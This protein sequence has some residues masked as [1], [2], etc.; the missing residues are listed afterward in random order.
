MVIVS[1]DTGFDAVVHFWTDR[2]LNVRRV[3]RSNASNFQTLEVVEPVS[4]DE[5]VTSS[6][7]VEVAEKIG[8][9]D[10]TEIYTIINCIGG[11]DPSYIH[12]AFVHFY[13]NKN[14]ENIYKSLK[15]EKFVALPVNWTKKTK[16]KKFIGLI[17]KY[18][19]TSDISVPDSL[20]G[21]IINNIVD[22]KKSMCDKL[23]KAYGES[24]PQLN[25]M[26]KP[27]YKTLTR[28]KMK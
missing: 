15:K 23:N 24:G 19:N 2:G 10:K 25:K 5:Y 12:L 6:S 21:F 3:P 8:G 14:G 11:E 13:G 4:D 1:N 9:V 7:S 20:P 26:F 17:I 28:I 18:V 16:M 27:F 22:D